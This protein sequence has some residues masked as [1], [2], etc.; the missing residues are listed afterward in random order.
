MQRLDRTTTAQFGRRIDSATT[1][2]PFGRSFGALAD[3]HL[4]AGRAV[5]AGFSAASHRVA[6]APR[7]LT[8]RSDISIYIDWQIFAPRT[9]WILRQ[10]LWR[11]GFLFFP[12]RR[13]R[14]ALRFIGLSFWT[15]IRAS[16]SNARIPSSMRLALD[17]MARYTR[18]PR[19]LGVHF[20]LLLLLCFGFLP[21]FLSAAPSV[22]LLLSRPPPSGIKVTSSLGFGICRWNFEASNFLRRR[23]SALSECGLP[24]I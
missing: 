23:G 15:R 20:L 18:T 8:D 6:I 22:F 14:R 21:F 17:H 7:W 19:A 11:L 10:G 24:A 9:R 4:V 2:R 16:R 1:L 12:R 5:V 3:W 13:C